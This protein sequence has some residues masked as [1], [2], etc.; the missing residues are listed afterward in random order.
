VSSTYG[1]YHPGRSHSP[2]TSSRGT[3]RKTKWKLGDF[4]VV[5][6][7]TPSSTAGCTSAAC[8]E[9]SRS[10]SSRKKG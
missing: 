6:K 4:N 5:H 7:H 9:S 8:Q 3:C 1:R 2:T 10:A